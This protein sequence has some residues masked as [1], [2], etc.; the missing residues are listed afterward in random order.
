MQNPIFQ[1]PIF[2]N[3]MFQNNQQISINNPSNLLSL[4]NSPI[5]IKDHNHPLM[6]CLTIER[7]NH[8]QT[9]RCNKCGGVF[10][11]SVPTFYCS[12]CDID[13]C[14]RCFCQYQISN[15]KLYYSNT[16]LFNNINQLQVFTW[17]CMFPCHNHALTLIQKVNKNNIWTCNFC[18]NLYRNNES[19]YYCT[20]CDFHLCMNDANKWRKN[21]SSDINLDIENPAYLDSKQLFNK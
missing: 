17:Q 10:L 3:Q 15:I 18:N 21:I 14:E 11:Y 16:N 9:W 20:L 2:Q 7:G 8:G 12:F 6:Y 13:L 4:I 19:F 1:E 5:L